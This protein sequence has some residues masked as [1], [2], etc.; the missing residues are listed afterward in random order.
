MEEEVIIEE[1]KKE[2]IKCCNHNKNTKLGIVVGALTGT[3][4]LMAIIAYLLIGFLAGIWHPSWLVFLA[5]IV[6]SSFITSIGEKDA[7]KF[8][9]PVFVVIMYILFSSLYGLWHPL[10][11]L[12]ITI[13][14]YYSFINLV[15][16]A[17]K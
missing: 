5:P 14:L 17:R 12:F 4:Y 16:K 15:R 10:W 11:V 9:Y 3:L 2:D 7:N 13:P 8:C 6:I 1:S